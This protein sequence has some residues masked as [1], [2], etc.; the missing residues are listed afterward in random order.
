MKEED[1]ANSNFQMVSFLMIENDIVWLSGACW[2]F[3]EDGVVLI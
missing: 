3:N 2:C 1:I